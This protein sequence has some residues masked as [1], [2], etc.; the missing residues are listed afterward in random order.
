LEVSQNFGGRMHERMART[1]EMSRT[2]E[3]TWTIIAV[4]PDRLGEAVAGLIPAGG[5]DGGSG[6]RRFLEYADEH[7]V[8][9]D[10]MWALTDASGQIHATVL[11]VP[12]PGQTA[13]LF[14]THP[15]N[16]AEVVPIGRLIDHACHGLKARQVDLAQ[17]LLDPGDSI[18]QSCFAEAQ[19]TMLARLSYMERA[20]RSA[21]ARLQVSLPQGFVIERYDRRQRDELVRL[22]DQT[23]IDTLDC[24]GLIGLRDARDI[25]TGHESVGEVSA[26]E[27]HVLRHEGNAVG[28]VMLNPAL[29]GATVELVYLGLAPEARGK[30]LGIMLLRAGL[31][32]LALRKERC[33]TLAVDQDNGPAVALYKREGF[34]GVLERSAMIRSLRM[35]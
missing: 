5:R 7:K 29:T 15:A 20:I 11:G 19:F 30:N 33:V 32:R 25:L 3:P 18:A 8:P 9:L 1:P 4:G 6:A 35:L 21:D 26:H 34:R 31:A 16:Q 10:A 17:A 24:P 23:Y 14:A 12:S 22:L 27:W 2:T 13:M 28:V